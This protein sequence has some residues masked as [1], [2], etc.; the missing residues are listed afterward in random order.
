ML[1]QVRAQPRHAAELQR[2]R[3]LVQRDPAQ[4]LVGVGV[5]RCRRRAPRLGATNS[6]RAG[7][8]GSSTGNSYWPS[9]RPARK[10]EIAPASTASSAPRRRRRRRSAGPS[11]PPSRSRDRVEHGLAATSGWPR[12][13]SWRS[14]RLGDRQRRGGDRGRCSAETSRSALLGRAVERPRTARDRRRAGGAATPRATVAAR[15]QSITRSMVAGARPAARRRR[16]ALRGATRASSPGPR[17]CARRPPASAARGPAAPPSGSSQ[18]GERDVRRP[19]RAR[20]AAPAAASTARQRLQRDHAVEPRGRRPGTASTAIVPIA[21]SRWRG[22]GERVGGLARPSAGRRTR[23]P[24]SSSLPSRAAA[25]A[26]RRVERARRRARRRS[27]RRATHS[28]PGPKSWTK[29]NTTS[30]IVGPSAT[31]IESAWCGSPRLAFERAVDRVDHHERRRSP[32]KSTRAALLADRGEA[33]RPRRAAPRA[34]RTPRPRRR[35]RSPACGRRPRRACRSRARARRSSGARA[36]IAQHRRRAAA[37]RA[38]PVRVRAGRRP[39]G[40]YPTA[41]PVDADRRPARGRHARRRPAARPRR[42]GHG[43]DDGARRALRLAGRAAGV[44]PERDPRA[45]P[46]PATRADALRER[47]EDAARRR[48]YEELAVTTFQGLCAR[49]LRDEALEAG[50][51]P[52]ATP[53][54]AADRLAMLLERIDELP[55][56]HH[57]LR[58]NPSAAARLD[59]RPHRPPQGRARLRRGLRAP[60]PRRSA[61]RATRARA[62]ER[63]FAALYARPRPDARARRGRSTSATS[64]CTRSGCCA[65]KPH[66]RARLAGALPARARRRAAGRELR[67]GPA[68]AAAGGR[69]RRDQ[70]VRGDDDQAIHRFRGAAT[71]NVA[72]LR[73]R[74]AGGDASCGWSER[75][76]AGERDRCAAAR[77]R[78]RADRRT[79]SRRR[80]ARAGDARRGRVLALRHRAR[81]GAGGGR[82]GRAAGRA[83]GRRARGRLRARA[84]GA[85]ARA[86]R[87][88]SRSRSAPCRTAWRA[89]RRSSSAPRCATCWP[90]CGCSSIR[91]TPAPSCARS[92]AR[93]SSCARSTSRACTQ[94]ARRRKLDMVAALGAALESPQIPPEARERIV[95]LPQ[96]L[97]RARRRRSTRRAPDL[98]VHRLIE[99]LG[100]RRQ[101]LFAA[102]T[103]VVERLRQPRQVRRAGRRLRAPRA[104]GHRARVRPL[105]RRGGRRRAARGGGGGRRPA[106]AAC[107]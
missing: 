70:R 78:G 49:L 89:R 59:R 74:V 4:Q 72:R 33:Q 104:A 80:C 20:S 79:G 94:I 18:R 58:G 48:A 44:A 53:V 3:D 21:R 64:C 50:I 29:P 6:S 36:R 55:L 42:R 101:L 38:E 68:A 17:A 23:C 56:R 106:R 43:Q 105:D 87:S 10:P 12:S 86:R 82:R 34:R 27:P 57:D 28:S 41:V 15:F 32:P 46:S 30:A 47:I 84:L 69:A 97:P 13:S 22:L 76:A 51:D 77:G 67:P 9:T 25:L 2:V 1:G 88:R 5:E 63:E 16:H 96:A 75:S 37:R 40:P 100:L 65:S 45:R 85:R 61:S 98:Y 39:S 60:G 81:A 102:S 19:P 91:A 62:R 99:R 95:D 66:V 11:P 35:R 103:E 107:R 14:T 31:A 83:R 71:K 54:A 93:R 52:F 7:A 24:S 92:R 90:G 26:E 73:G 8:S